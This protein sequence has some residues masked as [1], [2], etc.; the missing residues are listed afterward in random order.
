MRRVTLRV[1]GLPVLSV[2]FVE[3]EFVDEDAPPFGGGS[4]HNFTL[5]EPFVDERYEPW[6]EEDRF[7][8]R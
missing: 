5:A 2:D 1:F 6:E 4:T 8:F 3:L 7:G